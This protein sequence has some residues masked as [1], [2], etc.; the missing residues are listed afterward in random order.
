MSESREL[1][2]PAAAAATALTD[3]RLIKAV[4]TRAFVGLASVCLF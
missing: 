2:G 1:E 4:R 3:Q